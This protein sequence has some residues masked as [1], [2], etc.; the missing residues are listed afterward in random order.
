MPPKITSAISSNTSQYLLL[1]ICRLYFFYE[2]KLKS[3]FVEG[4]KVKQIEARRYLDA[5]YLT[6]VKVHRKEEL[7]YYRF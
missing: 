2:M 4:T 6:L 7:N 3:E 1:S 5:V